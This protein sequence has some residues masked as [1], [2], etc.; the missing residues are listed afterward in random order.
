MTEARKLIESLFGAFK[1][2]DIAYIVEQF[3]EHCP[4]RETQA[5]E[6]PYSGYLDGRAGARKF[7][8][9]MLQVL[10]PNQLE[11][12]LWVCEGEHVVAMG[13]WGGKARNTG[14]SWRSHL[15]L[16]FRVRDGKII[17][18]RGHDDTAVTAAALRS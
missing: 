2:G 1:R 12:D 18:F 5:P 15:A 3:A 13:T 11:A 9:S 16:Y 4:F 17:E 6:L 14:K 10:E 8:D 7:F